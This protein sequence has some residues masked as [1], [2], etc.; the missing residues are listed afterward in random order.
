MLAECFSDAVMA[1]S[2][3]KE[4]FKDLEAELKNTQDTILSLQERIRFLENTQ[5]HHKSV[6]EDLTM[7]G[8]PEGRFERIEERIRELEEADHESEIEDKIRDML[9]DRVEDAVESALSGREVEVNISGTMT[10]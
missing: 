5:D 10:L 7:G 2:R 4:A 6:L 8:T 3:F 1:L 9:E